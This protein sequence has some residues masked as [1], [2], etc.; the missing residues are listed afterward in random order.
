M[1]WRTFS[2]L[3]DNPTSLLLD[4]SLAIRGAQLLEGDEAAAPFFGGFFGGGSGAVG[5]HWVAHDGTAFDAGDVTKWVVE[6]EPAQVAM[7]TECSMADN[8]AQSVPGTDFIRPCNMCPHMKRITVQNIR[9]SLEDMQFEVEVDPAVATDA[10]AAVE[11]MLAV[12]APVSGDRR[13]GR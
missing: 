4:T 10:R 1:C 2:P 11:A 9:A 6:H 12:G 13:L 7:I 5:H 3:F 8:V